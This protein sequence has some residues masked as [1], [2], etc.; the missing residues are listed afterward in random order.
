VP[1]TGFNSDGEASAEH[2]AHL[3]GAMARRAV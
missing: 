3:I 1:S 2:R